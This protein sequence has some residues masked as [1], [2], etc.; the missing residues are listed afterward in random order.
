MKKEEKREAAKAKKAKKAAKAM[1]INGEGR[2]REVMG[3]GHSR[4]L[5]QLLAPLLVTPLA[6]GLGER[7]PPGARRI[8]CSTKCLAERRVPREDVAPQSEAE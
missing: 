6:E 5:A 7:I 2:R 3:G 4:F 1:K 8:C